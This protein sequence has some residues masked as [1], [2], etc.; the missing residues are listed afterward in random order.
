MELS[1]IVATFILCFS[2]SLFG[3]SVPH[4]KLLTKSEISNLRYIS[5][6]GNITYYQ[7]RSG[8]LLLS[9]N[10]KVEEV[11][12]GNLGSQYQIFSSDAD[13]RLLVT[14]DE[15]FHTFFSVRHLKKV[16]LVKKG[17]K[18]SIFLGEGL[19]PQLHLD[20]SWASFF[21]P[22][23]Q[24]LV[25]KNLNSP[26]LEFTIKTKNEINPFFIPQVIMLSPK[27]ILYTDINNK[28]INGILQHNRATKEI[29][30]IFKSAHSA[31]KIELCLGYDNLFIGEF[32]IN[33]NENGSIIAKVSLKNFNVDKADVIYQSKNN[34]F[35]NLKCKFRKN[36]LYFI[37]NTATVGGRIESDVFSLQHKQKVI[38]KISKI[39]Y[40]SQLI[41][42]SNRLLVPYRSE[43]YVLEGEADTST[44]DKLKDK[45]G[46]K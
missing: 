7:R 24:K 30:P 31:Q 35:G 27:I 26:A 20:D 9:T 10:Y 18:E 32:G 13:K 23:Q 44:S 6:D 5:K 37:K 19:S 42:M 36:F 45:G 28:G 38:K 46:E 15:S 25:F 43:F 8:N 14:Q 21:N 40:V 17:S 29:K 33:D 2:T 22:Y 4:P 11:L 34:D 3:A 16:Y 41:T 1:R 12:K 39:K